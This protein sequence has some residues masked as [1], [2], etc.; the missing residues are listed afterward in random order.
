MIGGAATTFRSTST[1]GPELR[2]FGA[3]HF[4][5]AAAI[6]LHGVAFKAVR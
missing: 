1:R 2:V 3:N 5:V 4:D 6:R